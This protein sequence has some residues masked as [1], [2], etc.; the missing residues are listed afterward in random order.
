[1]KNALHKLKAIWNV[2]L[3]NGNQ[4]WVAYVL[5]FAIVLLASGAAAFAIGSRVNS[6]FGNIGD[7]FTSGIK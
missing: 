2:L 1:M 3:R 7:T 6:A 4:H 5:L